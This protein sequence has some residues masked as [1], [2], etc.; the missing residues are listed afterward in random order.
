[1]VGPVVPVYEMT[2]TLDVIGASPK[3]VEITAG[4]EPNSVN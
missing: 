1:M 3:K 2:L 4:Y